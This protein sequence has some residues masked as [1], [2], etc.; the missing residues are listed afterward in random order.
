[1][2][3]I[4]TEGRT[5]KI[6]MIIRTKR[7]HH[8]LGEWKPIKSHGKLTGFGKPTSENLGKWRDDF[9]QSLETE[10]VVNEYWK[11]YLQI[12][13]EIYNQLTGKVVCTNIAT[14]PQTQ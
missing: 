5:K 1:M 7:G 14:A 6:H 9:K 13:L 11:Y 2:K 10:G 4:I 3:Q 12:D 8:F